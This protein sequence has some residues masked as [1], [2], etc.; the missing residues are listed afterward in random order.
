[1]A[2]SFSTTLRNAL[3][4]AV[5]AQIGNAGRL[6]IYSGT[7]PANV[8]TAPTGGNTLLAE[9][10]FGSPPAPAASG[11]SNTYNAITQDSSAD[12]TGVATWFRILRVDGTTAV[13]DGDVSDGA[14]NGD[15]KLNTTS[16]VIGGPVQITSFVLTAPG[17]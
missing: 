5:T 13:I 14:G 11:G 3:L 9:L 10:T 8:A 7:R 4:D 2:L 15:L 17:S 1:M 6:R 12:A 16:I